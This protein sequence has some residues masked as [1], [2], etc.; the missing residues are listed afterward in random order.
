MTNIKN[1]EHNYLQSI[2]DNSL[3]IAQE[4]LGYFLVDTEFDYKIRLAFG[5][6][7]DVLAANSLVRELV[8]LNSA[9]LPKIEIRNQSEIN[10]AKGAFA[11]SNNTLYL[12]REFIE[13]NTSNLS[14][15]ATVIIEELGHFIDSRLN[16]KDT[17]GDEGELFANLVQRV[18]LSSTE[19]QRVKLEYDSAVVTIDG[20]NIQIEQ[21]NYNLGLVEGSYSRNNSVSVNDYSDNWT[22][23]TSTISGN[24]NY[25][26][27][28]SNSNLDYDLVLQVTDQFG[29]VRTSDLYTDFEEVSL[30]GAGAGTYT[31]T[32]YDKYRG[33][34]AGHY[35]TYYD[36]YYGYYNVWV[37]DNVSYSLT[38]NAPQLPQISP[39]TKESNN[40]LA[41]AT[42]VTSG[43]PLTGGERYFSNL[44]IHLPTDTDFF[45]FTT[46]Q[47]S[48]YENYIYAFQNTEVGDLDIELYNEAGGQL[49]TSYWNASGY[50]QNVLS[51]AGLLPGTY[52]FRVGSYE[53]QLTP[54]YDLVFNLPVSL[55]S[56]RF[57]NNN[58]SQTAKN[59]GAIS[60]FK[61]ENNLSIHTNTDID[62]FQFQIT[63]Q[64]NNQ[65]Y[66]AI[67]FENIKGNLDLA[68]YDN[69]GNV[70]N[71]T[72][73]NTDG[74]A[75]SLWG[76]TSG[77]YYA[78][79]YSWSGN[80]NNYNLMLNAP[81]TTSTIT[82]DAFE[83]NNTRMAAK[84]LK[85]F[86][87]RQ[88]EGFKAWQNLSI[89]SGDEDWFKFDIK[90]GQNGNYV[91]IT[92][93]NSFNNYQGDL[94]LEL[95]NSSGTRIKQAA[96]F[97]DVELINLDNQ[98]AG[99]YYARV[100]GN[101]GSTN[102]NYT[103]FINTPGGDQFENQGQGN[104]APGQA[105]KLTHNTYRQQIKNLSIHATDD[106]DWFK[107]NLPS[108]G[109]ANDYIRIDFDGAVG[110]L[111]LEIYN[112]NGE[113]VI[114]SSEGVG[115]TEQISLQGLTSGDYLI[116]VYGYDGETNSDYTLTVNSPVGN[117]QDWLEANN[118]LSAAKNLNQYLKPGQ[119]VITIGDE[120]EKPLSIH[121]STD[122]DWFKFT[123]ASPAKAGDYAQIA[124][125]HTIGDLDFELYN[126]SSQLLKPSKG[127]A[128]IH[129]I[130]LKDL[131]IGDY[132][133]KVLGYN[134]AT[135]PTYTLTVD[136]PF[137]KITG[138]WSETNTAEPD[139]L[140][141]A[142]DLGKINRVFN[143]GNL[144][145]S[146]GDVDW[147]KFEI[148]AKGGQNDAVGIRF[149][150]GQGNLD[151]ELYGADGTT[152]IKK[153]TGISGT[154]EI[155]LNGRDKGV[156]YLKVSG[157]NNATNPNYELF[158][159]APENTSG[160][161][162]EKTLG[163]NISSNAFNLRDVE[164][165]QTWESLSIHTTNDVDWFKFTTLN[166]ANA[167]D[168]VRI[169]FD[170]KLGD[171]ELSLY[172]ATGTTLYGKSESTDNFEEL[173]LTNAQG[174]YLNPGTYL[175]KVEGYKQATNP[176]YQLL[177]NAPSGDNSD[178]AE[179]N[180]T[181]LTAEN[182]QEVQ[183]TQVYSGLSLHQGG[184]D[185]WFSFITKGIGV[186]GHAVS[187][188]FDNT[189]GDLQL[190]LYDNSGTLKG[191]SDL[192][193]NRERISLKG[194]VAG[195]YYVKVYGK[196]TTTT[197]PN[198]SL[199]ID[200]PQIPE[201]DWIDQKS[202]TKNFNDTRTTAYD[203][204]E[205]DGSLTL[206]GLSIHPNTDQDWFKFN[207]NK[208]GVAG[209]AVRIDFNHFEGDLKLELFDTN[210]NSLGLSNTTKNF[211][212]ISLTGKN[213]GTYYVKV[214]G[215]SSTA[216]N[217]EYSLTVDATPQARPDALE[218]NDTPGKAYDLRDLA[219]TAQIGIAASGRGYPYDYY[220][221]TFST[222][223]FSSQPLDV[224][225]S[226]Y[227]SVVGSVYNDLFGSPS[228][229]MLPG[230]Q[231]VSHSDVINAGFQ[232]GGNV[233]SFA[234][235]AINYTNVSDLAY[236][237]PGFSQWQQQNNQYLWNQAQQGVSGFQGLGS[238]AS[239]MPWLGSVGT[240][241]S[242]ISSALGNILG[243]GSL[244]AL[245]SPFNKNR[246]SQ[247]LA[248]ISNLSIDKLTDQDWFKFEL[249]KDGE[250][251]QFI[252]INFDHGQGDLKLELFE[253][254]NT[255]TNTAEAQYQTYL[256]DRA[257]G[258]GDTEQISLTGLAKGTY[259]IRVSGAIN[260]NYSLTLSAPPQP[261]DTGDWTE[262]NNSSS[263]TYDLKTVEGGRLLENLSI[264]N[265]T[266][267]DW[268]QFT[269]TGT[270][271]NG[272][273]VRIDFS[274]AQG[275]LDLLLYDQNG[276][277]VRGRSETTG[278]FEEIS[279]NTLP[280]GTYKVQVL[281]YN[282]GTNPNYSL[283]ILAPDNT[284]TIAPD[285]LEPNNTSAT[286]INLNQADGINT[287]SNLTI[288]NSDQDYFKFTLQ[289]TNP[290][291]GQNLVT[292][293]SSISIQ[294]EN[295]LGD[296]QLELRDQNNTL[297][298]SSLSTSNNE[299]ISLKGL[300]P[301]T[302]Y[303][304]V[305]GNT[306]NNTT[307]TNRYEFHIDAPTDATQIKNDWTVLVYMTA[308]DLQ[309]AAF[310]D[311]N[312]MEW[313]TSLFPSN[314]NFAVLW[315]QSS[316][317]TNKQ[318]TTGTQGK[319]GTTGRAIIQADTNM[320]RVATNFD[321]S[322]GE[323]NTGDP[324]NLVN[325]VNWAK[326]AAP[327]ENY[328]LVM[329]DH[330][331]GDLG[332]FNFDDEGNKTNTSVDRL[333]TNELAAAL[334]TLKTSGTTLDLL[335]FDACLMGMTEVAYA[336][337]DYTD[338][339]VASEELEAAEGYDYTT[340]FS[341][342][343]SN[344]DQVTAQDIASGMITSFQQQYQGDRFG[345]DTLSAI[346]ALNDTTTG[347]FSNF[348]TQLKAFTVA[349]VAITTSAT[350]DAIQDAR[351]AATSFLQSGDYRDLGQFLNAIATSNNTALSGLKTV[352]QSAYTAL[353]DLVIDKTSDRRDTQG[354][355]I[356]LPSRG[357]TLDPGYLNRNGAFFTATGW[358]N[359]LNAAI[360]RGSNRNATTD[361]ADSNDTAA[362]AYN[363]NKLI[364]DGHTFTNLSLHEVADQD[365]YRFEII[366]NG[367]SGDR[368]TVTYSS[369]LGSGLS[370]SIYSLNNRQTPVKPIANAVSGQASIDLA[371]LA[372]GEYLI[373]VQGNG[374]LIVPQYSLTINTPGTLGSANIQDWASGN[375]RT[376]K[377]NSLG[378]ITAESVFAGLRVNST[379]PDFFEFEIPKNQ[380][381]NP[382]RVNVNVVGNQS[383]TAEL[384]ATNGTTVLA[385]KT[386][387]GK[388]QLTY[389]G[390]A[391][392]TY[393]LKISQPS[394][395]NPVSYSLQFE[396]T[397]RTVNDGTIN[398][399]QLEGTSGNDTLNGG[400]GN[401]GLSGLAG[402]DI[403][404]GGLGNDTLNGGTGNDSLIGGSGDD[405][406]IIDSIGDTITEN[407]N[408]GTDTVQ[409]SITYTL[410]TN[411]ENLTLTGIATINAT[412]NS[413]NNTIIGNSANNTL[414]GGDGNDSLTGGAGNDILVGGV[415]ADTLTGGTGS[416]RFTFN[417]RTEGIDHITDFSVID[418]TIAVSTTG[419]GG[420]LVAGAVITAAQF[421][422]GTAATTA[423]Q[424]FIYNNTTGGMFFD[425]DGT[426]AIAQTQFAT[427]NT[428]LSLTNADILAIA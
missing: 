190:Q 421:A 424:R 84:S 390:E 13:E 383:V 104:N 196:T 115:N 95:Y 30:S 144:S 353:Q 184:D 210:G 281:G 357:S 352:A 174:T 47:I 236:S 183:G 192:N 19:L 218:V 222:P 151:I 320:N 147:F 87:W 362:R 110:D 349:A 363:F 150:Q 379:T 326:T 34:Y 117:N 387:T 66:I 308:S 126:S 385:T 72:A 181:R 337:K 269:T 361:W 278:N 12:S 31:I 321:I 266:D 359:F 134:G 376:A 392:K 40:S 203:L 367:E 293:D 427:L 265:S 67:D 172:D 239:S 368:L 315:D 86:G 408:E 2:L 127:I 206:S 364:G 419:F 79:V 197:N 200:A 317:D 137:T 204:R 135:N 369:T 303:S 244:S 356:Y 422:I 263:T 287:I 146:Q 311:I 335:A 168:F 350:W 123:I 3:L 328:A 314:V 130:D 11:I 289:D 163:N 423:S 327:A 145:I 258:N 101:N 89:S 53:G 65:H 285:N 407:A 29:Q 118:S 378:I 143:Q 177:I 128:N 148:D 262:P 191:T 223:L 415:G 54:S 330:G 107:L 187:I 10:G 62:W 394:G 75:L 342:L 125:D 255:T 370:L 105:T 16:A 159:N 417:S 250:E 25:V 77:I 93:D 398:N 355:S 155:S 6:G 280:A 428:G 391:G 194:L 305:F 230:Y 243:D 246:S 252:S 90:E 247:N 406:Y 295:A 205:I 167:T 354:L 251:G 323:L 139:T 219:R 240:S 202:A 185:D 340:A 23:Q 78:A 296:L 195:T 325:F 50:G 68:L 97:R 274:N 73:N 69:Q 338:V 27:V 4:K 102:P 273:K 418:D 409:S 164:G 249:S 51:L 347:K 55:S 221:Y 83:S 395:Q 329:W 81:G 348:V 225:S 24:N 152:L 393:Q 208:M 373:R 400:T 178:W 7:V 33:Q 339:F 153:S 120:P 88:E 377:A 98:P 372:T 166:T 136:A 124:F 344:P 351:N 108:A 74:E 404:N 94:D 189:Q 270:G 46:N 176:N 186:E 389:P 52:Y 140:Q 56:D 302:Y 22:F 142:K 116:K 233:H 119:Q 232:V 76:L 175:V 63:G 180:N 209:Q 380:I 170:Q 18:K 169:Q 399:D 298:R 112:S 402:N 365:W 188:E 109:K 397:P 259:F 99:T 214:S 80:T 70:I 20:Q 331:A 332:G 279:L 245:I 45:K 411:L 111:D 106:V 224:F 211:E 92:F 234:S 381:V 158:I 286:A 96:G 341:A 283:S 319:W 48:T 15:I 71:Y 161:W 229:S 299:S 401:D 256:V 388:L 160:D 36:Y 26:R 297:V 412:G 228:V 131:E 162:A 100:V 138:D 17:L 114:D 216:S 253:A 39:D 375:N 275:D 306:V 416:D 91:A 173:K 231:P 199:I 268:F 28:T 141:Q 254:F 226:P 294:F 171:L 426:G 413:F 212:E 122:V 57:E 201:S 318:Y 198:Y 358:N 291:D 282:N 382:G 64:T 312:E 346:D 217:P 133:L 360:S 207:L 386:G 213:A 156:Y 227:T 113:Q 42:L 324:N 366:G 85:D 345:F 264:H 165:L 343:L 371:G 58:T 292:T 1:F 271:K 384:L 182:L 41:S 420:G 290:N 336:L 61:Q 5:S 193:S 35:E 44:S 103:L 215:A 257:N 307:A 43:T 284:T 154:E 288:H 14:S 21:S 179:T 49:Y 272:H 235:G 129:R 121:N 333:Y 396:T 261:N 157:Y 38:I 425:Q 242:G 8:Q 313:A 277:T 60:G 238:L 82:A 374:S 300:T 309:S 267:Q 132:Y 241:L 32:V 37:P 304:R 276:T 301:G 322:I 414:N 316:F 405:T 59:L 237:V 334:N 403:I 310:D 149:N 260:P 410:G 248:V 220:Y 9:L